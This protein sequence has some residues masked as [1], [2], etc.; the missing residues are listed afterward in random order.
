MISTMGFRSR[1]LS[2]LVLVLP[3][4]G[5]V[6]S[7]AQESGRIDDELKRTGFVYFPIIFS[8]PETGFALGSAIGLYQ[9]PAGATSE[10]RPSTLQP[11][12][13]YTMKKQLITQIGLDLYLRDGMYRIILD[14][15]YQKYP[16]KFWGIGN[17]LAD[18]AEEDFSSRKGTLALEFQR[19]IGSGLNLGLQYQ[20]AR[21]RI[22]D[23]TSGGLLDTGGVPGEDGARVSGAGFVVNW[24]TR[25]N[26]F[27]PLSGR[28]Y[29]L[30]ARFY[31][32][33]LGSDFS[34]SRYNLDLREYVT[35]GPEQ[36]LACQ[37]YGLFITG[38][39]PFEHMPRLGGANM[40]RGYYQGRYSDE[41]M[42]TLQAEY[43]RPLRGRL[44]MVAFAGAG[45][46][47]HEIRDFKLGDFKYSF[48]LGLRVLFSPEERINLRIDFAWGRENS[49][50]YINL[51]EA[52]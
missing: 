12:F 16:D 19:E 26:I 14:L 4:M 47:A 8:T 51:M 25:D 20:F 29:Q 21:S 43:R 34:Y 10:V 23:V 30:S 33:G 35:L 17:D 6:S 36:I 3:M 27:S 22:I 46:V 44:G 1:L 42:F 13:I 39:P 37:A 11:M 28:W 41:N 5:P 49:G 45:D 38:K 9:R 15:G 48:G 24:D 52:F 31:G 50:M 18:S 32:D 2:I 40:M 7:S